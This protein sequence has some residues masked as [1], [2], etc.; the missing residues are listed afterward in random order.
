MNKYELEFHMING[1]IIGHY[2]E[3][4]KNISDTRKEWEQYLRDIK[5]VR[6]SEDMS[7]NSNN[8]T[9]FIVKEY[10]GQG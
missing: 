3:T 7:I 10:D 5:F 8:V 4:K 6:T 1:I 2:V 9:H